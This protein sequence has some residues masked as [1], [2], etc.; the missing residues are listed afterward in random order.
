MPTNV[1][2]ESLKCW[3]KLALERTIKEPIARVIQVVGRSWQAVDRCCWSGTRLPCRWH[4]IDEISWFHSVA[5]LYLVSILL[6]FFYSSGLPLLFLELVSSIVQSMWWDPSRITPADCPGG[7]STAHDGDESS[8]NLSMNM[9]I[10]PVKIDVFHGVLLFVVI[11]FSSISCS[12]VKS[13]KRRIEQQEYSK[14]RK[15]DESEGGGDILEIF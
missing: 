7:T 8:W 2:S 13:S 9:Y 15:A 11:F 4:M 5:S 14:K 6:V 12:S 10:T 3:V 1:L